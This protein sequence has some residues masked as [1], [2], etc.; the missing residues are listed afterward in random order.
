MREKE[1]QNKKLVW[2]SFHLE[3]SKE[4]FFLSSFVFSPWKE[5]FSEMSW[6]NLPGRTNLQFWSST[7]LTQVAQLC[8]IK[9]LL[10]LQIIRFFNVSPRIWRRF[11]FWFF[12]FF[13]FS[14]SFVRHK[15]IAQS[16]LNVLYIFL[17]LA[18]MD[19]PILCSIFH[20]MIS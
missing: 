11:C 5:Q 10:F 15:E 17:L 1:I 2:K 14:P 13:F 16:F 18:V 12:F 6:C 3:N 4:N 20:Q 7:K 19:F 9:F 8:Y